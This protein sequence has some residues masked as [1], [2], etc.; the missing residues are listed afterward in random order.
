MMI[1]IFASK[2]C[3]FTN[4]QVKKIELYKEK[5]ER[6][7]PQYSYDDV[8]IQ[9]VIKRDD[10][11]HHPSKEFGTTQF[12]KGLKN[13]YDVSLTLHIPKHPLHYHGLHSTIDES[14]DEG[15]RHILE[16]LKKF[17]GLQIVSESTYPNHSTIRRPFHKRGWV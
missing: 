16:N 14:V 6:N 17:K 5:L 9:L 12:K 15:F 8:I 4:H 7:L 1:P 10:T 3:R 11:I 2:N 13:R